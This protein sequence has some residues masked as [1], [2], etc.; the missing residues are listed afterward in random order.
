MENRVSFELESPECPSTAKAAGNWLFGWLL[1]GW[2]GG[3][4]YPSP[5]DPEREG[6]RERERERERRRCHDEP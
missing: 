1:C 2:G 6:E 3:I 5:P 4:F